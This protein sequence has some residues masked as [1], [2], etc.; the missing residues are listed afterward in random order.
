MKLK[1]KVY[2]GIKIGT[3]GLILSLSSCSKRNIVE[4][5]MEAFMKGNIEA[6]KSYCTKERSNHINSTLANFIRREYENYEIE[7]Y[8]PYEGPKD[9]DN[10]YWIRGKS[11]YHQVTLVEENG[12]WKIY[13]I[14]AAKRP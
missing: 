1:D 10:I 6:M 7:N 9:F 14:S 5:Y 3:L 2:D 12:K 4:N 11:G 13:D 8:T